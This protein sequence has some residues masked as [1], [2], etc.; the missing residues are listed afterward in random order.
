[1][2]LP[3]YRHVAAALVGCC[4]A[5]GEAKAYCP[6]P[7]EVEANRKALEAVWE[8]NGFYSGPDVNTL[9]IFTVRA[10]YPLRASLRQ[11]EAWVQVHFNVD[12]EGKVTEPK[13]VASSEPQIFD[14]AALA[15][16]SQWR[17]KPIARE[18]M[19]TI[20]RLCPDDAPGAR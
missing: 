2:T 15:A 4:A 9:P 19:D 14:E 20:I 16:I 10:E 3:A 6:D 11:R 7:A 1:M 5:L 17:Y 13:V 8:S 12:S 18:G